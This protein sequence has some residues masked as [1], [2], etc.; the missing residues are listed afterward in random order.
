MTSGRACHAGKISPQLAG[1]AARIIKTSGWILECAWR[2]P[3]V[4]ELH[5][6]A[7]GAVPLHGVEGR[8]EDG[9]KRPVQY[10]AAG[11]NSDDDDQ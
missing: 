5:G 7:D 4:P 8:I 2:S 3:R 6:I 1:I 10:W 11:E 9:K